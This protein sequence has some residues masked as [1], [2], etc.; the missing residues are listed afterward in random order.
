VLLDV[1]EVPVPAVAV[2]NVNTAADLEV[3]PGEQ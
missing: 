1:L 3:D 2:R